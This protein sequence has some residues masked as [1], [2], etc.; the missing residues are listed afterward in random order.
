MP[1]L[2]GSILPEAT[3]SFATIIINYLFEGVS[4]YR[5]VVNTAGSRRPDEHQVVWPVS[6]YKQSRP[7]LIFITS[8]EV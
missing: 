2:R 6:R 4:R 8:P 5:Q 3:P 1:S 7:P